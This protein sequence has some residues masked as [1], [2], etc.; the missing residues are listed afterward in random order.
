MDKFQ[1]IKSII[2]IH[3]YFQTNFFINSDFLLMIEKCFNIKKT[4][5]YDWYNDNDIKNTPIINDNNNKLINN[6]IE[7]FVIDLCNK[8]KKIGIKNIKKQINTNFKINLKSR[9]INYIFEPQNIH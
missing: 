8:N 9:D 5:F 4:T 2:D 3:N 1:F 7:T 6:A